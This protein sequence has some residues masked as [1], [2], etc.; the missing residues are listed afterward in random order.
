MEGTGVVVMEGT[1]V[2][3]GAEYERLTFVVGGKKE[4]ES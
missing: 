4:K 2:G 1:R 3:Y